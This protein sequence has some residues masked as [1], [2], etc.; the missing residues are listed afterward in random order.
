MP[1][2]RGSAGRT[3]GDDVAT[4]NQSLLLEERRENREEFQKGRTQINRQKAEAVLKEKWVNQL[5][6]QLIWRCKL[7]CCLLLLRKERVSTAPSELCLP[8]DLEWSW[9][10]RDRFPSVTEIVREL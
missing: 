1:V 3:G 2:G 6:A 10:I 4:G 8:S 9:A 5:C 7:R